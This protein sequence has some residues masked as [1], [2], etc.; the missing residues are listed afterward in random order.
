MVTSLSS[1]TDITEEVG[2]GVVFTGTP[3]IV[4][5]PTKEE[6]QE[7][8]DDK[9]LTN[10][11]RDQA[12]IELAQIAKG[13]KTED[14]NF[15]HEDLHAALMYTFDMMDR[16]SLRWVIVGDLAKDV[17]NHELYNI[18]GDGVFGVILSKY[19]TRSGKSMLKSLVKD[20]TYD[21]Q[22]F[23]F[24]HGG[25]PIVLMV[26][27]EDVYGVF[28]NPEQKIYTTEELLVP[29]PFEKYLEQEED[30]LWNLL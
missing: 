25:V 27:E 19:M 23:R 17:Y 13:K 8:S 21:G 24:E 5:E 7:V 26:L 29:N 28:L 20:Y 2:E 1:L 11:Q 9:E 15:S 22:Y 10:E 16:S 30:I 3:I 6:L 18:T 4:E 14:G 12:K